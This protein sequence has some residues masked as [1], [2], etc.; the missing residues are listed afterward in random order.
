MALKLARQKPKWLQKIAADNIRLANRMRQA[1]FDLVIQKLE[2][3]QAIVGINDKFGTDFVLGDLFS[4][5]Q[6][7]EQQTIDLI[8]GEDDE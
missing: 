3:D 1:R 2:I 7:E 4:V 6:E 8:E 5:T